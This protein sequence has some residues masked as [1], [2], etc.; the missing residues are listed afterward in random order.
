MGYHSCKKHRDSCDFSLS[1]EYIPRSPNMSLEHLNY[2]S[3]IYPILTT[4][5]D[6]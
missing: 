3:G 4:E 2:V 6:R 5:V 1:S